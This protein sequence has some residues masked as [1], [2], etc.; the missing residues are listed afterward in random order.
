MSLLITIYSSVKIIFLALLIIF[1]A[2]FILSFPIGVYVAFTFFNSET[3]QTIQKLPFFI[4]GLAVP[5]SVHL[6]AF[7][8]LSFLLVL[9][10]SFVYMAAKDPLENLV[11]TFRSVYK[12]GIISVQNNTLATTFTVFAPLLLTNIGLEYLQG[13]FG[14]S[15]G[16]LPKGAPLL[17]FTLLTYAPL[18]EEFG[19]RLTII[20]IASLWVHLYYG[21]ISGALYSLWRPSVNLGDKPMVKL[22]L[23]GLIVFSALVFGL[24]H[25]A[26]GGGWEFGKVLPSFVAGLCL[27]WLY[28]RWG[29]HAAVLLHLLFNYFAGS[30]DYFAEIVSSSIIVNVVSFVVLAF[31]AIVF[32]Y[33]ALKILCP[34]LMHDREGLN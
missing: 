11:K 7:M 34:T 16:S 22:L 6:N 23:N 25:V 15:T 17:D 18:S 33:L 10:L 32:I 8:L 14:V 24:A 1:L 31:G 21:D 26:Y 27:G 9:Y 12:K 20:G 3:H 13:L 5:V 19:F 2:L 29:F 4:F 30:F 28:V